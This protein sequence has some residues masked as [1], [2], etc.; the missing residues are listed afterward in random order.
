MMGVFLHELANLTA[1]P[2]PDKPSALALFRC[3]L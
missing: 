3:D 1:T 2:E